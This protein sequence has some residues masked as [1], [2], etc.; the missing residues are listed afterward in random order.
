MRTTRT[1]Q[2]GIQLGG[3]RGPWHAEATMKAVVTLPPGSA[4]VRDCP[5]EEKFHR[6]SRKRTCL[7]S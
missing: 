4:S 3:D 1:R 7:E 5:Y 2:G 6:I